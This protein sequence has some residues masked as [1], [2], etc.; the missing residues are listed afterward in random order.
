MASIVLSAAGA[1]VGSNFG[2]I[3]SAIGARVG[4]LVGGVIDNNLFGQKHT[5]S[6]ITEIAVQTSAYGKMI[7]IVYGT[8]RIAGN[9][10][11]SRPIEER[12]TTTTTSQ[13]GG[14]GGGGRVTQSTTNYS[15]SVSLAIAICEGPVDQV[16]RIW[17]DALVLDLSHY[18]VRVYKG[19][20]AQT[21]DSLMVGFDGADATPAYRGLAYAVF[22]DFPLAAF[23]NR[24]PNFTFEVKKR[25]RYEDWN[26]Q[27]TEEMVSSMTL[28]PGAGEFVYDTQPNYKIPGEPA[29]SG[30][31]QNGSQIAINVHA[32]AGQADVLSALDN[33]RDTCPNAHW[34]SVVVSWFGDDLDAGVCTIFPGVEYQLGA[35]TSPELWAVGTF[36]RA[37][38]RQITLVE[39]AP[40]YGGT[41][42][43]NAVLRL[44][45]ELRARGYQI[46]FYPML[47]MDVDGKPWRGHMS[48]SSGD[49]AA[50][51]TKAH[52]FNAFITH[53]AHLVAGQ[54]D[55][56]VIGSELKGL[57]GVSSAPGVYP[58][59]DALVA[60]AGVVKG[61][62]GSGVKVTYAADWSEYHHADGGWYN[63]DPLWACADIDMIGIDAYFPLTTGAQDSRYD[64]QKVIDAWENGEG[65][66]YYYTDPDRTNTA[67]LSPPYAWKNIAWF[68][69]N[70][71]VNPDSSITA[72]VPNA[73][74]I[75]FTEFGFPSID[76]ATN[77]PNIFYDPAS[78]DSGFPYFSRGRVDMRAQRCGITAALAKWQGSSMVER[79]FLW[80]WDARPYPYFPD[81]TAV[82]AD[83]PH[84]ETGHW[85]QGKLGVSILAAII[86]DLCGRGGLQSLD[87]DVSA[88]AAPVFGMAITEQ[89]PIRTVIERLSLAYF[90]D[91]VESGG[92]LKFVPRGSDAA[93]MITEE[94]VIPEGRSDEAQTLLSVARVQET[95]LPLRINVV[96]LNPLMSYQPA[97]QSAER[98]VTAS[99][100]VDTLTL[101]I[102][103]DD[104]TAKNIAERM[105]YSSWVGRMGYQF[106]VGT[107]YAALDPADVIAVAANGFTHTMRITGI[108]YGAP[109]ML[110]IE[111]I[112]EEAAVYD[113]YRTPAFAHALSAQAITLSDTACDLLDIPA[114]PG[115]DAN[116]G[117]MRVAAAGVSGNWNGALLYR[118]DDAG[119]TYAP[120][121]SLPAAAIMGVTTD[122]LASGVATVFDVV[123][124]LTV[125]LMGDATLSSVSELAVLNGA[126]AAMVGNELIQFT[127][128]TLIAPGKYTLTGLLRGRQGTEWAM[129]SHAIGERFVLLNGLVAAHIMPAA[130]IG[131]SRSYKAVSIG[132]TIGA[133]AAQD[134]AYTGIAW[135]PYAPVGLAGAR[136]GSGNITL[137]WVRRTRVSGEW[138]D[139]VDVPLNETSEAYEVE[140]MNGVNVVRTISGLTT[141]TATYSAS[142]Q[143]T[144]FGSTQASVSVRV[145]QLSSVVGRGYAG[146]GVV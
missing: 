81:L 38:A 39:G 88:I 75:W 55:A 85:V 84:W 31:A 104:Q 121:L 47:F 107:K 14:K 133:T 79:M 116:Q 135:K 77:Q 62:V 65:W 10:I 4:S 115:D 52:G 54:V 123:N 28:I 69:N 16:L 143:I 66:E 40:R 1:A 58:A 110:E 93:L 32:Y 132:G 73:K 92:L 103:L 33:V 134:V 129:A 27:S 137:T 145:Y 60:L 120:Q 131:L 18:T 122:V 78:T 97:T 68:W 118:S 42:S 59:V 44:L 22:E 87:I 142:E 144:D 109:G 25:A 51:F 71:H 86:A 105:L 102:V 76:G 119:G 57:T 126:N 74:K 112:A 111:A 94:D 9:L 113:F 106:R 34:I 61:V 100:Q 70:Y 63:L 101:P 30:W 146:V 20:E 124:S 19:D 13:R 114:L 125:V 72:W 17:A 95:E 6:S 80:T 56:F 2:P 7:P 3:G 41:P 130:L 138:Q 50:F 45:A 98:Q 35:T 67:P 48:G 8:V 90:F 89:Q 108:N 24:I 15:Y 139:G 96:Y 5:R 117:L 23:G 140:I 82:W 99:R 91:A 37:T 11:W 141:P 64:V 127:A 83:G 26:G 12:I 43:D 53:Y 49:V 46:M 29:G 36:T 128:A 21:A 136:D